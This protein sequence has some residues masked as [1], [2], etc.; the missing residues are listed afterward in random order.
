[1]RWTTA[2]SEIRRKPAHLAD[3]ATKRA[4]ACGGVKYKLLSN[5]GGQI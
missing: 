4:E 2:Q 5:I 3:N 1:M